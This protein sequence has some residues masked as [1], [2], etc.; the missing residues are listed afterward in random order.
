MPNHSLSDG[1]LSDLPLALDASQRSRKAKAADAPI[2]TFGDLDEAPDPELHS[3]PSLP[4]R[5]NR[6]A[7]KGKTLS[8]EESDRM[9]EEFL[10]NK[11]VT[12]CPTRYAQGAVQSVFWNLD[13][14]V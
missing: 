2:A 1:D 6:R 3:R 10:K 13:G 4:R 5:I 7:P 12:Q 8:K 11:G 9:V 14:T